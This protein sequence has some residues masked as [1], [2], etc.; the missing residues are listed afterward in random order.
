MAH[1][2]TRPNLSSS[3][4][5]RHG[6]APKPYTHDEVLS[7][8]R[9]ACVLFHN[10]SYLQALH[11]FR[12]L[13]R[14]GGPYICPTEL[15]FNI[16]VIRCHLGE[17]ALAAESFSKSVRSAQV[18]KPA[19]ATEGVG[20]NPDPEFA[21]GWFAWG[22]SLFE[23]KDYSNAEKVFGKCLE[24]LEK[25]SNDQIN[26]SWKRL[27]Y[28]LNGAKVEWNIKQATSEMLRLQKKVPVVSA[29][30][31]RI[32]A[33]LIFEGIVMQRAGLVQQTRPLQG[34]G[35][36]V[37]QNMA[38]RGF[39]GED[40]QP[41]SGISQTPTPIKRKGLAKNFLPDRAISEGLAN[42][43]RS[44]PGPFDLRPD[45]A[46][47]PGPQATLQSP[48][49]MPEFSMLERLERNASSQ[50]DNNPASPS[51]SKKLTGQN[52]QSA[53]KNKGKNSVPRWK[54]FGRKLK[55]SR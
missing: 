54:L 22:I 2:N 19:L 42:R 39:T 33:E 23:L 20:E 43:S 7:G 36:K 6:E 32:P 47:E 10:F 37:V 1:F 8:H 4:S 49:T 11:V 13:I 27:N 30:I 16:G 52:V 24:L 21:I 26:Y 44:L 55:E 51:Q 9:R 34:D 14:L 50:Q 48:F 12:S 41:E 15:W 53:G 45:L 28:V 3:P 5:G 46:S 38:F 25:K 31:N 35:S 17:Y 18:E 40:F 29:G